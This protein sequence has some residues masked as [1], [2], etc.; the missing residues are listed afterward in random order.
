MLVHAKNKD[1]DMVEK[2]N[3]EATNKYGL[4]PSVYRYN[5]I[6]LAYAKMNKAIEAE[7]V[8]KEM[9]KE[10]LQ[11][12]VVCYTTVIDAYKR[13]RNYLKCWDL[14]ENF[15]V[16]E[17]MGKDADEFMLSYMIRICAFTHDSEKAIRLFNDLEAKGFIE[18]SLPYNSLI[19]ALASTKRYAE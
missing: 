10:G 17:S 18:N 11:P 4:V 3:E 9:V 12:D 2:L 8:L 1:I 13:E 5:A 7:K 6:I 14:Y 15:S 16:M 19:F